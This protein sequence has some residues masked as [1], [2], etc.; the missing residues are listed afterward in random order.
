V[1]VDPSSFFSK[2]CMKMEVDIQTQVSHGDEVIEEDA[3]KNFGCE[4][5]FWTEGSLGAD[6]PTY[7]EPAES[8][9]LVG[10]EQ[11]TTGM[12]IHPNNEGQSCIAELI[13]EAV[14]IQLGVAEKPGESVCEG[15]T[16]A[17]SSEPAGSAADKAASAAAFA[18]ADLRGDAVPASTTSATGAPHTLA[19]PATQLR[20]RTRNARLCTAA[21][22]SPRAA[23]RSHMS[24]RRGKRSHCATGRHA[25]KHTSRASRSRR[26]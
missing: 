2:H 21:A 10:E 5:P 25:S 16:D 22:K 1:F 26:R 23:H 18:G 11:E 12:G 15:Q 9:V 8:G 7:L 24:A 20:R 3:E 6:P 13:W 17:T 19:G 4:N 14:K